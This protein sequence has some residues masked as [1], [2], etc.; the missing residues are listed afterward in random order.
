MTAVQEQFKQMIPDMERNAIFV[1]DVDLL[2]VINLWGEVKP[3]AKSAR[4]EQRNEKTY[5]ASEMGSEYTPK[6][7]SEKQKALRELKK[8]CGIVDIPEDYKA[9][10]EAYLRSKYESLD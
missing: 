4:H 2:R 3:R 6:P 10:K 8:F 5:T 7:V 1:Q 9:E